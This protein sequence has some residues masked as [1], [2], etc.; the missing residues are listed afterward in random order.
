MSFIVRILASRSRC[1]NVQTICNRHQAGQHLRHE[2][3]MLTVTN[4][5]MQ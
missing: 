1:V 4:S 2:A 3:H 5:F